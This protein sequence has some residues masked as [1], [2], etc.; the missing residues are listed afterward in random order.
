MKT[1]HPCDT[2]RPREERHHVA[3]RDNA[4]QYTSVGPDPHRR[5]PDP[6]TY[7]SRAPKKACRVPWGP[8]APLSKVRTLARSRNEEEPGMSRGPVLARVQALPYAFR[9]GGDPLL[10]CGLWPMM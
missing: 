10:L 5:T 6:Y 9:S 3:R 7:K 2:S 4:S 1:L 8:Q